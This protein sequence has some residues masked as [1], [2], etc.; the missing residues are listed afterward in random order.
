VVIADNA[1]QLKQFLQ[2]CD[3]AKFAGG[4]LNR[5]QREEL[6]QSARGFVSA[7]HMAR[8]ANTNSET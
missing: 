1:A 4:Q 8:T 6:I 7:T 2:S 3:L 5:D